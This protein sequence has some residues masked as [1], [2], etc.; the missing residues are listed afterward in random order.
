M[1]V[2]GPGFDNPD[3]HSVLLTA[4]IYNGNG[5]YLRDFVSGKL[6]QWLCKCLLFTCLEMQNHMRTFTGSDGRFYRNELCL[7]TT[8]GD[9]LASVD[10]SKLNADKTEKQLLTQWNNL[11]AEAKKT[12]EY[13]SSLTYGVYQIFAEIDT[14]YKDEDGN[15]VWNNIEVHSALQTLKSLVKDYYNKEIV[16]TLFEYEFLK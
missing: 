7:D 3:L 16:P 15:T 6:D 9:T 8:N 10:L 4:G 11:L 5:F 2:D 1:V 13:D 12:A 14:S